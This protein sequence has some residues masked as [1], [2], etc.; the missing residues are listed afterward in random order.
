MDRGL[1]KHWISYWDQIDT[2]Q[3][4]FNFYFWDKVRWNIDFQQWWKQR[5]GS[6]LCRSL[7]AWPTMP[8][9][10][11]I[12]RQTLSTLTGRKR[13][14]GGLNIRSPSLPLKY[15]IFFLFSWWDTRMLTAG[16]KSIMKRKPTHKIYQIQDEVTCLQTKMGGLWSVVVVVS[17][18]VSLW[19]M[20]SLLTFL[21]DMYWGLRL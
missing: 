6:S 14:S 11:G 4:R 1:A 10:L 18:A 17:K 5:G 7:Q 2:H 15:L 3:Q 16:Y 12:P 21:R 19:L 8:E 9:H 13:P 20:T